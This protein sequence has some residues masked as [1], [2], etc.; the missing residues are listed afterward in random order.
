MI[1][2]MIDNF[3]Y[4]KYLTT[5]EGILELKERLSGNYFG[6]ITLIIIQI[7]QAIIFIFPSEVVEILSGMM[8]G[9]IIGFLICTVGNVIAQILIYYF[10]R[11]FKYQINDKFHI[12]DLK[13]V[14]LVYLLPL[15][16]KD[17]FN[18]LIPLTSINKYKY[19]LLSNVARIPSILT[20]VLL[21]DLTIKNSYLGIS[22]YIITF[23]IGIMILSILKGFNKKIT[24]N[25][26]KIS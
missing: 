20:S 16:P 3:N 2:F 10:V 19:L 25:D 24:M 17:L 23:I 4:L 9:P 22:I 15:M 26:K 12:N 1:G 18:Y 13:V 7:L 11:I 8:Y 14:F 5:K 6:I 21:I